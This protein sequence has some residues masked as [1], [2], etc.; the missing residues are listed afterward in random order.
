MKFKLKKM[1]N[2]LIF[3]FLT[4]LFLN[5][6]SGITPKTSINYKNIEPND[7]SKIN[8]ELSE[9]IIQMNKEDQELRYKLME[10]ITPEGEMDSIVL[11][12][13]GEIDMRNT[14][15]M[16]EI[17]ETYGWPTISLVGKE[18]ASMAIFLVIHADRDTAFQIKCLS[19]MKLAAEKEDIDL[20]SYAVLID[21]V[22]VHQDKEQIYGTQGGCDQSGWTADPI[23]EKDTIEERRK[24]LGLTAFK[25]YKEMMDEYCKKHFDN[26]NE[27]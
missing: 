24:E 6:V 5:N 21:R 10:S 4:V 1:R 27:K 14:N 17:I 19:L 15:R 2:Y 8:K 18:A 26:N 13:I 20:A 22:L 12:S 7:S 23:K 3:M 9:E 25:E 16:K 11:Q